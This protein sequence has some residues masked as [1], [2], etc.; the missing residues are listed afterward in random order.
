MKNKIFLKKAAGV[1]TDFEPRRN[2]LVV[3]AG[4]I[5]YDVYVFLFSGLSSMAHATIGR[6]YI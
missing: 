4:H 2:T 1:L 3:L 5:L 6:I